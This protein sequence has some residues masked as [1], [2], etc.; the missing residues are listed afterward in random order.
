MVTV[1]LLLWCGGDHNAVV[2]VVDVVIAKL[3]RWW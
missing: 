2:A 3:W 1:M